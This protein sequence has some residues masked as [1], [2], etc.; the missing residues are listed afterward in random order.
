M[1]NKLLLALLALIIALGLATIAHAHH[2]PD[3]QWRRGRFDNMDCEKLASFIEAKMTL[4][5]LMLKYNQPVPVLDGAEL[6]LAINI[7]K[8]VCREI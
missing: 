5:K 2:R 8:D 1:P 6:G 4:I 7:Y 3:H